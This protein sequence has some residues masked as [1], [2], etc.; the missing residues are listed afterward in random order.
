MGN[1][2][3]KLASMGV[4]LLCSFA[5]HAAE[6]IFYA[7]FDGSLE[8]VSARGSKTFKTETPV[9]FQ[10]GIRGKALVIG[11]DPQGVRHGVAYP[12]E[13]NLNWTEGAISFWLKPVNW[14]G[15]DTGFFV[16]VFD[17]KAGK[18]YFM[19]YKYCVGET[20]YFM[21]GEH[22]FWLFTQ[23]KPGEW[24]PG[25]WHH[26]VCNWNP[27]QLSMYIDG[28]LVTEQRI[29][30]PLRN[31]EPKS[32][33]LLGEFKHSFKYQQPGR[34]SLLDEFKI[35]DRM[36][37]LDEVKELYRKDNP[38]PPLNLITVG[39]GRE[40]FGST[41][42]SN[43]KTGELSVRQSH[44]T[45]GY[46][47]TALYA[48]VKTHAP[49]VLLQLNSPD[50][51]RYEYP[52]ASSAAGEFKIAVPLR[53]TGLKEGANGWTINLV[54]GDDDLGG[55][56]RL[57][58]RRDMPPVVIGSIY[59]LERNRTALQ[60]AAA[61]GLSVT[62]DTDTTK[63]YGHKRLSRPLAAP[64]SHQTNSIPDWN[65]TSLRLS[66]GNGLVYRTDLS[67]RRNLPL[68][69][70][71]LYTLL[72]SRELLVA[73][74]G[75][76]D[77]KVKVSFIDEAGKVRS[78]Q[79]Q[80]IPDPALTFFNMKFPVKAAPGNY[81]L[82][83]ELTDRA[84]KTSKI[85]EQAIRIPPADDPLTRPYVDP[86]RDQLP[87]GGWTPVVAEVASASVW[88]RKFNLKDGVLFSS[89]SS[90][91]GELYAAPD[92][93]VLNGKRLVPL[94]A[95]SVRKIAS[96]S[97]YAEYE[98]RVEYR[99]LTAESRI[100]IHFDGYAKITLKLIP[101]R[102]ISV[103]KL[104]LELP[105]C[106]EQVKLVRDNRAIGGV[107]GKAG[108]SFA[109]SL[110]PQPALWIGNF[111]TGLNLTAENLCGWQF[112]QDGKHVMMKRDSEA[113]RLSLLLASS[114][115][116]FNSPREYRFGLTPT[117]TKPLN[118]SLLRRRIGKEWQMWF[119]PWADFNFLDPD[120]IRMEPPYNGMDYYNRTRRQFRELFHYSAFNFAGPF[121]PEWIWYEELWRQIKHN[122]T[123][124]IWTG[125]GR[126]SYAE[127]CINGES[128][129]NF[130]LNNWNGFLTRPDNPLLRP[131]T[132]N[133][134]FD[135]PWEE[136]C[137]NERHGCRLWR[138]ATGR[139]RTHLLIDRFREMAID[140][141]R[142]IKRQ[143]P[144]AKIAYHAEWWRLMP[145]QSFADV[146]AGGEGMEHDVAS[147]NGYYN[148]LTPHSFCATFSPYLWSAKTAL[149]PQVKRGLQIGSPQKYRTYS[150]ENPV[151]RRAT[152]HYIGLAAVN[153]VDLWDRNELIARWHDAQDALGWND[154]TKFFPWYES[155]AVRV[156]SPVSDRI[157]ASAY[158]NSG[159]LMLAVLNDTPE[160]VTADVKLDC[161]KLGVGEG[162]TGRDVW[163]PERSY[164]LKSDWRDEI[165]PWGFRLIVF[166]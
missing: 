81:R 60:I 124:G 70:K 105:L 53:E 118:R 95:P 116:T 54:A 117:P 78:T 130:R 17:A 85:H 109:V 55:G 1:T 8:P 102:K 90:Q 103:A 39:Y 43:R 153:D 123:Y 5:L 31:L 107:S 134:Y 96:S 35:F 66:S 75:A 41:G 155:D 27:V 65:L 151:W 148:L 15:S 99:E 32:D 48:G 13:K 89:L 143:G 83:F 38:N 163:D 4:S 86:D 87:P 49:S 37:T 73:F 144:D 44:Y 16:P 128:Y 42:F 156:I 120:R 88:G 57:I 127:G 36:L 150:L 100:R 158:V 33:F 51:K 40:A 132:R 11:T 114:P 125:E 119:Q 98:K 10:D 56:A 3:S 20:F 97:L 133:F 79:E 58:L 113:A 115:L 149:I 28:R 126:D 112:R 101:K 164:T 23:F 6:P 94:N 2:I 142:M 129:R 159:R 18:N 52:L 59:D 106:N 64:L 137:Y 147:R 154:E 24:K 77:G 45:L 166:R 110:L 108:D 12:H 34:L 162:L 93:L 72:D 139:E 152:L 71:F 62:F 67:V 157:V 63:N 7:G 46:D 50:G 141:Y 68:V 21:R 122:R 26:V 140:V 138:D 74:Q 136:S 145:F 19:I 22:G 30:F 25:E 80:S 131:G 61:D 121:S 165:P 135:A 91:G 47:E 69:V 104:A 14:K 160:T 76:A 111:R 161:G 82:Q 29:H 84:G 92:A 9:S 146:L